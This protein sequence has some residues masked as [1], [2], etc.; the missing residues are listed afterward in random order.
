MNRSMQAVG[1]QRLD[2]DHEEFLALALVLRRATGEAVLPAHDAL[3]EHARQH[4]AFE[5]ALMAP[6]DFASKACHVDEHAAVLKSFDEVR[7][8]LLAGRTAVA[9]R[10][11][12][13]IIDWLPEH[14]DALDRQL[15]KYIFYRQTGGAPVLLQR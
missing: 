6:H 4:F 13:H 14:V 11:A 9:V 5:D 1:H 15:A 8:A 7:T 10:F 12:D 2:Q 3:H